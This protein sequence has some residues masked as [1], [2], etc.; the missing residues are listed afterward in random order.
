MSDNANTVEECK[1][2]IDAA[3]SE[4]KVPEFSFALGRIF[5]WDLYP[6]ST[7][8]NG[9]GKLETKS[10]ARK[11]CRSAYDNREN[12][13]RKN[14]AVYAEHFVRLVGGFADNVSR[15]TDNALK[16]C[17]V[18][19]DGIGIELPERIDVAAPAFE[20][21]KSALTA[22]LCE[23]VVDYE[24]PYTF[25]EYF[26]LYCDIDEFEYET[27][28]LL[29]MCVTKTEYSC[30]CMELIEQILKDINGYLLN[31]FKRVWVRYF[32]T[33]VS[34][35]TAA[36]ALTILGERME[37]S[38]YAVEGVPNNFSEYC[39]AVA[40]ALDLLLEDI[41]SVVSGLSE[42]ADNTVS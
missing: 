5:S 28:N 30:D 11:I 13:V 34:A 39:E 1:R 21:D 32:P 19:L 17:G 38:C 18:L 7:S 16:K 9:Y 35:D 26:P 37:Q 23:D 31:N 27:I 8:I 42:A 36:E 10:R 2:I 40:N 24:K 6:S 20:L 29:G 4:I 33:S 15:I 22:E 3:K 41:A 14:A 25:N 12:A